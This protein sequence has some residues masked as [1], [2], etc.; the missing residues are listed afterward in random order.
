[1]RIAVV[2]NFFP[3]RVGGS[4]HL[5]ELL[6]QHYVQAGH[7]VLVLTTEY[8]DAPSEE[9]HKGVRIVRLPSSTLPQLKLSIDFDIAFAVRP[10]ALRRVRRL[11]DEF[12]PDV[13]HQHGQ[14]FDLT[15][16]TGWYARRRKVPV[17]LSV[18]TRLENPGRVFQAAF[19]ALDE[20]LV[21]PTLAL[22][23][24]DVVVMDR[25]MDEYIRAR[26]RIGDDRLVPVPVGIEPSRFRSADGVSV[27]SEFGLGDRPIL[28]SLGHVI[29]VRDRLALVR[30]L[31][32]V[33]ERHPD[34][35]VVVVGDVHYPRFLELAAEL[36]VDGHIVCV[37]RQPK[38]R[39]PD[40]LVAAAIEVHDLMGYGLG[41]ASLE[42]M[43]AGVP[44]V[45]AVRA[46]N[47]PGLELRDRET[48][49]LVPLDD[50]RALADAIDELLSEPALRRRIGDAGR[51]FVL[52]H[53]TIEHVAKQH[54]EHFAEMISRSRSS[55]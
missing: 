16:L 9:I 43:A 53:F 10:G 38:N 13:I 51:E 40:F 41:T 26:Y 5:S 36:G 14:F 44:I 18:H 2:N 28:L 46:D 42:T 33:V 31:P 54:L 15:W 50:D 20:C 12:R 34:L 29:P 24:P 52:Q 22:Y 39:I 4:A 35:A 8:G 37:G 49:R 11:L 21:R 45:A 6:A 23:R 55:R 3:P 27:R 32:R 30:A 25:L 47:F 1:M 17:L 7:E 48:L 19:R